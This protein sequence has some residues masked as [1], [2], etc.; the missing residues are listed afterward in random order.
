MTL[1]RAVHSEAITT[2]AVF[3]S[4]SYRSD[5]FQKEDD[6]DEDHDIWDWVRGRD[7]SIL[8]LKAHRFV[9][10]KKITLNCRS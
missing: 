5:K 9:T 10:W 4:R 3:Q 2:I 1:R 8:S 6:N 7:S